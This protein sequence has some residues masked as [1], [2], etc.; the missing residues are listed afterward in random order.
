V[1]RKQV[2]VPGVIRMK[3]KGNKIAMVS[4]YDYP[5]ARLADMA[6]ADIILVGDS[7]GM[8]ILGYDT[9]LPVTM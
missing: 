7:L 6:G 8:V 2:T 9:T 5:T 4:V 1:E 3:R